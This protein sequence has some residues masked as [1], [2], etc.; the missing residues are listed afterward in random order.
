MP[1]LHVRVDAFQPGPVAIQDGEQLPGQR[2]GCVVFRQ[3]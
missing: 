2:S 3:Q 1:A